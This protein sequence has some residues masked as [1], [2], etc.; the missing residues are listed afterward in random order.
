MS[1]SFCSRSGLS[2]K[3]AVLNLA[4]AFPVVLCILAAAGHRQEA[5]YQAFLSQFTTRLGA[6][7]LYLT[8]AGSAAF[9]SYAWSRRVPYASSALTAVFLCLAFVGPA[10]KNLDELTA[11]SVPLLVA[12][13]LQILLGF[14]GQSSWRCLI[15]SG[16]LIAA[17]YFGR[18]EGEPSPQRLPILFHATLFT[19]LVLGSV[20]DDALGRWLEKPRRRAGRCGLHGCDNRSGGQS[21]MPCRPGFPGFILWRSAWFWR[22]TVDGWATSL[23]SGPRGQLSRSGSSVR[24][25]GDTVRYGT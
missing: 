8:L 6:T 7:P 13:G 17:G 1:R 22:P 11:P 18:I 16:C 23:R 24:A 2:S 5:V 21:P 25:G 19:L 12:A 9:Y 4:L 15:G 14:L 3:P 20:F 10:T